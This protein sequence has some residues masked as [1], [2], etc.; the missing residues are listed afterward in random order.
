MET[1]ITVSDH[2]GGD[3]DLIFTTYAGNVKLRVSD[4]TLTPYGGLV[5]WAAFMKH[6]GI[7][8]QLARTCPVKRTSPNAAP[9]RDVLQSFLLTAL[10]DGRR[11]AHVQRLREERGLCELFG[12]K[13][14][15]SD[16]TLRRFFKSMDE[17]QAA[18]WVARSNARL[19]TLLPAR[20][21]LEWDSTVITKYGHQEGA[22]KG[23]NPTNQIVGYILSE[24]PTYIT[25]YNNARSLVRRID[26]DDL[27]QALV[28]NYLGG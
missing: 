22:Q 3:D 12:M 5:P 8:E 24:D 15:V 21:I 14:V 19:L 25:T 4:E 13:A 27:M 26:R 18:E 1:Q 10:T 17:T 6:N 11:F 7:I 28:K 16:D 2:P 20:L 9:V 23:Y